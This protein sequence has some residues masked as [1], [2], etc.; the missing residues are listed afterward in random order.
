M[1]HAGH[2]QECQETHR[3]QNSL[4]CCNQRERSCFRGLR[5]GY[6]LSG[7]DKRPRDC[8]PAGPLRR[9]HLTRRVPETHTLHGLSE[10]WD[11]L[12]AFQ[13]LPVRDGS[14]SLWLVIWGD[15]ACCRPVKPAMLSRPNIICW[16][17]KLTK[18]SFV[19]AASFYSFG[20][21]WNVTSAIRYCRCRAEEEP[22]M[23]SRTFIGLTL[24]YSSRFCVTDLILATITVLARA[25][26]QMP[27]FRSE[28][29]AVSRCELY[30]ISHYAEV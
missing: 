1:T 9:C 16:W 26:L 7:F 27:T 28:T 14:W 29:E 17:C 12:A 10:K 3:S 23:S 2:S 15:A 11:E 24:S 30:P 19:S 5:C 8:Y 18:V 22:D 13:S 25:N 6:G 21:S 20:L 4:F